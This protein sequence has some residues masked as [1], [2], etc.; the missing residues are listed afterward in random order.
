MPTA[1]PIRLA[2]AEAAQRLSWP[3]TARLLILLL[4]VRWLN[5]RLVVAHQRVDRLGL[6]VAGPD[7]LLTARRWL[8][9]HEA[10][11]A[12]LGRPEPD[13]VTQVRATLRHWDPTPE[14]QH[15]RG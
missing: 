1:L 9:T 14:R 3:A 2:T 4:R 10:I 13:H 11:A 5:R 8:A 6:D 7:L 12:L 15:L